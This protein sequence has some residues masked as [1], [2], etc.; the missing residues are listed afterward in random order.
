MRFLTICILFIIF[1]SCHLKTSIKPISEDGAQLYAIFCSR[2]HQLDGK[3]IPG[4]YPP[5]YASDYLMAD[6]E[7]SIKILI[8]GQEGEIIVNGEKYIGSM[9]TPELPDM[10]DEE[11]AV[12]LT[13]IRRHFGN[14]GGPVTVEE[15]QKIRNQ[16]AN[17]FRK[18]HR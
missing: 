11:I 15:I 3:G 17:E 13:Y 14:S 7:R 2:C 5:I 16:Y 6:K 18:K 1:A 12:I 9:K 8:Y 10:I 4:T